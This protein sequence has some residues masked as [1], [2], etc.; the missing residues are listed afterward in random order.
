[1]HRAVG[2]S[3]FLDRSGQNRQAWPGSGIKYWR[4]TRGPKR[5]WFRPASHPTECADGARTPSTSVCLDTNGVVS[6]RYF[7]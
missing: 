4:H 5:D 2:D 3:W 6:G 7:P 1:V